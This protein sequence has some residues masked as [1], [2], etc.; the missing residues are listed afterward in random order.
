MSFPLLDE[1]S[2]SEGAGDGFATIRK[3]FGNPPLDGR[4][5]RQAR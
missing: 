2:A 1:T 4:D 5:R 3:N